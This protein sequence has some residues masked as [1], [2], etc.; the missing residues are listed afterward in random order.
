MLYVYVWGENSIDA[1]FFLWV[2]TDIQNVINM[3]QPHLYREL[4][5]DVMLV[6]FVFIS[7]HCMYNS[8]HKIKISV[9]KML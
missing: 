4:A 9:R 6:T 5:F 3:G 7:M 1:Q 2:L 8:L